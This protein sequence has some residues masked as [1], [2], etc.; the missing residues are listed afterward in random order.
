[1]HL[2][3]GTLINRIPVAEFSGNF[4]GEM[5]IAINLYNLFVG[6]VQS[7]LQDKAL[8]SRNFLPLALRQIDVQR[9]D[10]WYNISG[11]RRTSGYCISRITKK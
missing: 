3:F 6:G 7:D 8:F 11:C 4:C 1:M 2:L 9:S 5:C 10:T